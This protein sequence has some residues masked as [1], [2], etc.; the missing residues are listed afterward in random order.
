MGVLA[1]AVQ[2][3]DVCGGCGASSRSDSGA[4]D[5]MRLLAGPGSQPGVHVAGNRHTIRHMTAQ[6][7]CST[8][9]SARGAATRHCADGCTCIPLKWWML[10]LCA[11][12]TIGMLHLCACHWRMLHLCSWPE[13]FL[14]GAT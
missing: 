8:E 6:H 4:V 14:A 1:V 3:A 11:A 7:I 5:D 13:G 2:G 10:H 9:V 12:V